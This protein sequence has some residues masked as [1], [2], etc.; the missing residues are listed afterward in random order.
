[1]A[2]LIRFTLLVLLGI[3]S[4]RA[5]AQDKVWPVRFGFDDAG[6]PAYLETK[7]WFQDAIGQ[8]S[9]N[10]WVMHL[11]PEP[12]IR[13]NIRHFQ[14]MDERCGKMG[15][16]WVCNLESA[17]WG[18]SFVDEKGRDW[19]NRRDGRHF[20]LL[21]PEILEALSKC[22]HFLGVMYDEPA[23]MQN[24]RNLIAARGK[25]WKPYMYEPSGERLEDA[26]E[27][28]TRAVKGVSEIYGHY[29][30]RLYTEQVFPVLF[31]GFARGGFT[32]GTK[33]LKESWSPLFIACAMGAAIQ[34]NTELWVTPD[35]WY[36][37]DYPGHSTE[38]L[39]SALLI[40]YH[41]GADS[42]YIENL[43]YDHQDKGLGSLILLT[44]D[45]YKVTKHGQVA[46]W[47]A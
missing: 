4:V 30:I 41:M 23:H 32:T 2:Q 35:L 15:L 17:N 43:A 14:R 47:F 9:F 8:F 18:K 42:I 1:M 34:Y 31:H 33:I 28:F 25:P 13:K 11:K 7:S 36:M 20:E 21:P 19:F 27:G 3:L 45:G 44:D 37:G 6:G 40:A 38:E 46:R 12:N 10:L 39:R 29:G 5:T 16:K 26:A 24:A 22:E